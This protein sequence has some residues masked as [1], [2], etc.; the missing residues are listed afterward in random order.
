MHSRTLLSAPH[1]THTIDLGAVKTPPSAAISHAPC[2]RAAISCTPN[3]KVDAGDAE[4][5]AAPKDLF[6]AFSAL[7]RARKRKTASA[8][9]RRLHRFF[10]FRRIFRKMPMRRV[11]W[12]EASKRPAREFAAIS[13]QAIQEVCTTA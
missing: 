6:I 8:L 13:N 10:G 11:T 7:L 9:E 12:A 5:E 3:C 4:R 1:A 2:I